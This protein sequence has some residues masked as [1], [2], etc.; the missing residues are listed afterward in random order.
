M[1]MSGVTSSTSLLL[2]MTFKFV[3]NRSFAGFPFAGFLHVRSRDCCTEHWQFHYSS[4]RRRR[5]VAFT[6][7]SLQIDILVIM[8]RF[9][10]L[11]LW[12][13]FCNSCLFFSNRKGGVPT[14]PITASWHA[15]KMHHH[16]KYCPCHL[17]HIF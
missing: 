10:Q 15:T 8:G 6:K 16:S 4:G 11:I 9:L 5:P 14:R 17:H 2:L 1:E 3:D 12:I 7:C 13:Q